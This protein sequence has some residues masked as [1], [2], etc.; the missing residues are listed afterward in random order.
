MG[1]GRDILQT[2][3]PDVVTDGPFRVPRLLGL[4]VLFGIVN[5]GLSTD[6]SRLLWDSRRATSPVAVWR[7]HFVGLWVTTWAPRSPRC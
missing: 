2:G 7:E 5:F 4:L 3:R 1:G 6:S